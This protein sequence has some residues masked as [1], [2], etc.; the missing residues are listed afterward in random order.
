MRHAKRRYALSAVIGLVAV[1]G[2]RSATPFAGDQPRFAGPTSSQ[3]LALSANDS[4]LAVANPDNDSVTFFGVAGGQTNRLAEVEVGKE[5]NG[6]AVLPD[7]S[8]AYVANT[9]NGTVSVI[10]INVDRGR[11]NES[12]R[13][14]V[15]T[16]PYGLALTPN[17]TRL[18]VTNAR[19]N[20]VSVIDTNSDEVMTTIDDAGIEPRGLAIT[21]D[22]DDD[23]ADEM[24][25]VT[26]FLSLPVPGKVDGQDDAKVGRVTVISTATNQIVGHATLN[27]LADTGFKAA[28]DAI[29]RIPPANPATFTFTTGAYPNQLNNIGLKGQFAFVPNTGASPNGPFRF[30][31]N[32]QSLLSVIDT[33]SNTEVGPP[34]NMHLAVS[35]QANPQRLFLTQPWAL[36]FRH[37]ADE[38]Y[39]V[40]AASNIVFKI[41]VDTATGAAE[42][43]S[44][45]SDPTRVL[46]IPV[47]KNPRGIVVNSSDTLAYVMNYVSRDV[48]VIQL[49]SQPEAVIA[50]LPSAA[51]PQAGTVADLIHVGKELYNTSVGVFDPAPGT[52]NPIVG[53]MSAAGWG[54]CSTCHPNGLSDNVVWIFP[55]GPKRTIPQHTDFD[56]TDPERKTQ[57]IL[58][59]SAERDEEEDFELNIRAVS[60]GQGLIVLADGVTQDPA[61]FNLTPLASANRNQLRVHGNNAWDAIKAYVQFGIRPPISPLKNTDLDVR[62]GRQLFR[63]ANCQACHG[64]PQWTRALLDYTPPPTAAQ[65]KTGQ[66]LALLRDV[67][68]FDANSLNEVN[69]NGAPSVGVDGFAPPS[70]LSLSAFPQTFFHNGSAASLD[71]VLENVVHRTAGTGGVD[72]LSHA[73]DREQIVRFLLSIDSGTR[74]ID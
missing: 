11:F 36:A 6:V 30:N 74:P 47:G 10:R 58:N 59:W 40:S 44:D 52:T 41:A 37:G 72:V 13:V 62:A 46:E 19:S 28:G 3:P 2:W 61:V 29:G 64:G 35:S 67:G 31:V 60:G 4:L 71:E 49:T 16:E 34:L 24:V 57:K 42:V 21:N 8:K 7:G 27:P 12:R 73:S 55:S 50:T 54:A 48:S 56:L 25:Y 26:Q 66:I 15:G 23:D 33:S 14:K 51:L 17:G 18:Y 20:S 68:T 38:G 39:V 65:I 9:V 22:N 53:R 69:A 32:T 1:V 70:L 63:A 5:P 45:P 43:L